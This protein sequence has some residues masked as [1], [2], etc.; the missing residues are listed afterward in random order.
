MLV[1]QEAMEEQQQHH[2]H[3]AAQLECV[4]VQLHTVRAELTQSDREHTDECEGLQR[5][6]T[7]AQA[8]G[9]WWRRESEALQAGL[10]ELQGACEC[11][12][13]APPAPACAA[14]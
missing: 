10:R 9:S 6:L 14:V 13:E 8:E 4:R 5:R 12:Q 1:A 2:H 11:Q 3:Q 7:A